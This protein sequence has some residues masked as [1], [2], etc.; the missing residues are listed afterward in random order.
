MKASRHNRGMA[1]LVV[2][3]IIAL[4]TSLL[5]EMA[6]STLVDLRLTETFRDTTRA[7]YLAKGGI[8]AGRMIIQDDR[9]AYDGFDELWSQGVINYPVGDGSVTVRIEDQNGKLGINALVNGNTPVALMVDRFYRLFAALELD[10]L[11][12]PAELTA[13]LIDWLDSG[14]TSY[15]MILTDGAEIPVAGAEAAYYQ[16]LA[17]PYAIKNGRL[18][19]LEELTL[20][21]GFTPDILRRILP[22]VGLHEYTAVNINTASAAV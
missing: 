17:Q 19:T 10:D 4:L 5:T 7:Y 6:F 22:H 8:N 18:E 13:A 16:G 11:G 1:L 12:D 3:V 14:D 9:N 15:P 20:I 2:L 21:K